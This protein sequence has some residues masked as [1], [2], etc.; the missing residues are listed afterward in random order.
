ML[1]TIIIQNSIS[2]LKKNNNSTTNSMFMMPF[3]LDPWPLRLL[4]QLMQTN[5]AA[6]R[7][8]CHSMMYTSEL[9]LRPGKA[10]HVKPM[11]LIP[12]I[13]ISE[14]RIA[15]LSD[16]PQFRIE[17][18][19]VHKGPS[20]VAGLYNISRQLRNKIFWQPHIHKGKLWELFPV[21][22]VLWQ[23]DMPCLLLP[24]LNDAI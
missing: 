14:A 7:L 19:R 10:W 20:L 2:K 6:H 12:S 13:C 3:T 8:S 23:P 21:R 4:R 11:T 24:L 15:A 16:R 9:A 22:R 1:N 5:L 18:Q 17:Q